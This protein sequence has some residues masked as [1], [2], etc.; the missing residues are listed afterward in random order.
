[1][2]VQHGRSGMNRLGVIIAACVF[3]AIPDMQAQSNVN[4]QQI[5]NCASGNA[6]FIISGKWTCVLL[7]PSSFLIDTTTKP[8][9]FRLVPPVAP[10]LVLNLAYSGAYDSTVTP[11]V[12]VGCSLSQFQA[13]GITLLPCPSFTVLRSLLCR[14]VPIP[15]W[16]LVRRLHRQLQCVPHNAFLTLP[17]LGEQGISTS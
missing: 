15:R 3:S 1:M 6:L 16:G 14:E 10:P 13:D 17:F 9:T 11:W 7:D 12:Q 5:K 4:L 8:P 2:D